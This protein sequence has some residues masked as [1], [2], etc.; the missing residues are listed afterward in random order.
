[1]DV[2]LVDELGKFGYV[3]FVVLYLVKLVT[4][5]LN[6]ISINR[7]IIWAETKRNNLELW[8]IM[9]LENRLKK[10]SKR[11][12]C[13]VPW[14]IPNSQLKQTLAINF[15][16]SES[17]SCYALWLQLKNSLL[18]SVVRVQPGNLKFFF[19]RKLHHKDIEWICN[20]HFLVRNLL[21]HH[22]G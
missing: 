8:T 15:L 14:N 1:M 4:T 22:L 17:W 11:M 21:P 7:V 3:H 6:F 9:H 18:V 16:M 19:A 5:L 2:L 13:E 10:M 12:I 20:R